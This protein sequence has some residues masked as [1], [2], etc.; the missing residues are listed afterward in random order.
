ME[1]FGA[2]LIARRIYIIAKES[3]I[4]E[5][6]QSGAEQWISCLMCTYLPYHV[7]AGK[8][9]TFTFNLS[10]PNGAYVRKR[11]RLS[12]VKIMAC[13]L[14]MPSRYLNKCSLVVNKV[15]ANKFK[16][17]LDQIMHI[18]F[19]YIAFVK[20]VCKCRLWLS[21]SGHI[22]TYKHL[23]IWATTYHSSECLHQHNSRK[24]TEQHEIWLL[25]N[26][27]TITLFCRR[28]G[29]LYLNCFNKKIKQKRRVQYHHKM[30]YF[31]VDWT[32]HY[33]DVITSAM[34]SHI[35]SLTIVYSAVYSGADKK[36]HQSSASLVNIIACRLDG[37]NPLNGPVL[38]Y[39]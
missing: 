6:K 5:I 28:H 38:E 9:W 22:K 23:I 1:K 12:L 31:I 13:R 25:I 37:A 17:K 39:C 3:Y 7:S 26:W 8:K 15:H 19:I 33:N 29:S 18:A 20:T 14:S 24:R 32:A 4:F 21:C 30:I 2:L 10:R 27:L 11:I 36:K 16:W 34:A 35:T